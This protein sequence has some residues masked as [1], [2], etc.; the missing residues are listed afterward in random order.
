MKV[1]TFAFGMTCLALKFL[2]F[3][4]VSGFKSQLVG[5][6]IDLEGTDS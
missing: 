1:E 4:R 2:S 5:Y 3:I 6:F